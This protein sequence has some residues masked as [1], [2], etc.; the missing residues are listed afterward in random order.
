MKAL[1]LIRLLMPYITQL[2]RSDLDVCQV[3]SAFLHLW[4]DFV[5]PLS[6]SCFF[7]FFVLP[8]IFR[9]FAIEEKEQGV[10]AGTTAVAV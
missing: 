5:I 7:F 3:G 4:S 2:K 10:G 1:P 8:F 9:F 6:L